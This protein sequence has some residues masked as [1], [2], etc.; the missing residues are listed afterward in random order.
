MIKTGNVEHYGN[1]YWKF[2]SFDI[3]CGN[4]GKQLG[5]KSYHRDKETG[6][7]EDYSTPNWDWEYCPFCG[8]PLY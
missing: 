8:T 3:F 2:L 7:I 5:Y 1:V 6:K 4:C